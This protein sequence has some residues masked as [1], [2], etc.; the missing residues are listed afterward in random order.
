VVTVV[1]GGDSWASVRTWFAMTQFIICAVRTWMQVRAVLVDGMACDRGD[2]QRGVGGND[3]LSE[4]SLMM[5]GACPLLGLYNI[6]DRYSRYL[7]IDP[8]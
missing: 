6:L 1:V 8:S 7:Q 5:A 2:H 3:L 4:S